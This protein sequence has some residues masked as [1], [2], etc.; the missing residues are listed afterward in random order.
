MTITDEVNMAGTEL[1]SA[2]LNY[3]YV[4]LADEIE[5]KINGGIYRVGEKLPS[6]R[7]LHN[8][9]GFSIATVYQAYIELEKRGIVEPKS[10]SGFYVKPLLCNILPSPQIKRHKAI[11]QKVSINNLVEKIHAELS[12][13][14]IILE[15][16]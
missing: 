3:R 4:R 8:H 15:N 5:H 16:L 2:N 10:K 9:T 13:P 14:S 7:K 12:D 11:P 1:R 6:I